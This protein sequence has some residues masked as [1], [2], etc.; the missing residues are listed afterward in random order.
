MRTFNQR[1]KFEL[2]EL[3]RETSIE[4]IIDKKQMRRLRYE[5]IQ[6]LTEDYRQ[7]KMEYLNIKI[8]ERRHKLA[9]AYNEMDLLGKNTGSHKIK[10]GKHYLGCK[11]K[12]DF[13]CLELKNNGWF[14][15]ESGNSLYIDKIK[16][17]TEKHFNNSYEKS[18]SKYFETKEA[19]EI[20]IE[21]TNILLSENEKIAEMNEAYEDLNNFQTERRKKNDK[22]VEDY[23]KAIAELE[24]TKKYRED[25]NLLD[26]EYP[27]NKLGEKMLRFR[28]AKEASINYKR[29]IL[30]ERLG[31]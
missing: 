5:S 9:I 22:L 1:R 7:S 30:L 23:Q 28:E 13:K 10:K 31:E 17:E 20:F 18:K 29:N 3:I 8:Q 24:L 14:I 11:T 16:V 15:Y 12:K 19:A 26:K 21:E 6:G 27:G 4:Q 25:L 2:K